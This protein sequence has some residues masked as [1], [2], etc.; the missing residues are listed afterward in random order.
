MAS[1]FNRDNELGGAAPD[2]LF[3]LVKTLRCALV[4]RP[5]RTSALEA[6]VVFH[7]LSHGFTTGTPAAI[8]GAVA[9][10]AS[11]NP[12]TA[13]MAAIWPSTIEI[14]FPYTAV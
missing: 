3:F 6:P 10:V 8:K 7:H 11:V 14:V 13:A 12:W 2:L 9:R 1:D 5:S 4:D